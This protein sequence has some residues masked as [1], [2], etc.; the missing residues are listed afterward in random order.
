MWHRY[1][2]SK[3]TVIKSIIGGKVSE[4]ADRIG[5]NDSAHASQT[6]CAQR[7]Q[8]EKFLPNDEQHDQLPDRAIPDQL[9]TLTKIVS[10]VPRRSIHIHSATF[11]SQYVSCVLVDK[12]ETSKRN[13]ES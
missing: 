4:C 11:H 10:S 3:H 7:L 5:E 12:P 9:A 2:W 13:T 1:N 6:V 8:R